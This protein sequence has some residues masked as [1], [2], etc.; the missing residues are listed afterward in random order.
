MNVETLEIEKMEMSA[1]GIVE[2]KK[3]PL[4]ADNEEY[5]VIPR[6]L[7]RAM[8]ELWQKQMAALINQ[9]DFSFDWRPKEGKYSVSLRDKLGHGVKDPLKN[10][11]KNPNVEYINSIKRR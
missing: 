5:F 8:P 2:E 11:R 9:L 10:Y 6:L 1:E 7:M 4:M 3:K